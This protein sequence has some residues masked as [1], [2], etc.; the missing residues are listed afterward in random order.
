MWRCSEIHSAASPR[1][2]VGARRRSAAASRTGG[3]LQVKGDRCAG[4]S[5]R[6]RDSNFIGRRLFDT[7]FK[8]G[9]AKGILLSRP[10]SDKIQR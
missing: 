9:C 1:R 2:V 7:Q 6:C 4:I 8:T 3:E 10:D 5:C